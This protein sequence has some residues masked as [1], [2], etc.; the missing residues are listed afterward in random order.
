[1]N[2]KLHPDLALATMRNKQDRLYRVWV[3]ARALNPQGSS[4]VEIVSIQAAV[5]ECSLQGLGPR[6]LAR[7]LKQ[8]DGVWWTRRKG[9]I[10]LHSLLRVCVAL[11]VEKLRYNPMPVAYRWLKTLKVFRAACYASPFPSG[12]F[13]SNP[14]SRRVLEDWAGKTGRT[15]RN[16][17][18]ALGKYIEKRENVATTGIPLKHGTEIPDGHFVDKVIVNGEEVLVLLKRLPNS[19]RVEF[20]KA[21]RGMT[22]QVNRQLKQLVCQEKTST[23]KRLFYQD[24]TAAHRRIQRAEEGDWLAV[25]GV[26]AGAHKVSQTRGGSVLW[27]PVQVCNGQPF[28]AQL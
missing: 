18:K 19:F 26:E 14:I 9:C 17:D 11:E 24:A 10:Y 6:T 16:Y 27:T 13:W 15:Q 5:K 3:L 8:G 7:L 25:K 28:F 2:L 21:T 4:Y 12:S 1:M 23:R 20:T 22:R